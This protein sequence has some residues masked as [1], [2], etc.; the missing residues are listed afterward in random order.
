M[1][2]LGLCALAATLLPLPGGAVEVRPISVEGGTGVPVSAAAAGAGASLSLVPR[3]TA[4]A[5]TAPSLAA[6]FL[7]ASGQGPRSAPARANAGA[8]AAAPAAAAA[9]ADSGYA[10]PEDELPG[11]ASHRRELLSDV[12]TLTALAD[13]LQARV[14]IS[15]ESAGVASDY[16]AAVE[17]L[18]GAVAGRL[19]DLAAEVA[20]GKATAADVDAAARELEPLAAHGKKIADLVMM[21]QDLQQAAHRDQSMTK[22]RQIADWLLSPLRPSEQISGDSPIRFDAD[23][24]KTLAHRAAALAP[25]SPAAAPH[26]RFAQVPDPAA[27][28]ERPLARP[29]E[30]RESSLEEAIRS[31]LKGANNRAKNA[32][33]AALT[34]AFAIPLAAINPT[35]EGIAIHLG[36]LAAAFG[37]GRLNLR[38]YKKRR[39]AGL[40]PEALA[41]ERKTLAFLKRLFWLAGIGFFLSSMKS[42]ALSATILET[43]AAYAFITM[44]ELSSLKTRWLLKA[45]APQALNSPVSERLPAPSIAEV[46]A[47][48]GGGQPET[49]FKSQ[50]A[51]WLAANGYVSEPDA[52]ISRGHWGH[53]PND[54]TLNDGR[55]RGLLRFEGKEI[56]L[57]HSLFAEQRPFPLSWF[58]DPKPTSSDW[59]QAPKR[60]LAR[61]RAGDNILILDYWTTAT[62][63][64]PYRGTPE[65]AIAA[66]VF[67]LRREGDDYQ[68]YET[69]RLAI[70]PA[71]LTPHLQDPAVLWRHSD[72]VSP[73]KTKRLAERL[74]LR[75]TAE[76][77]AETADGN[78]E[79]R[80]WDE[81]EFSAL[82]ETRLRLTDEV[83]RLA[84]LYEEAENIF[85]R[86]SALNMNPAEVEMLAQERNRI[87]LALAEKRAQLRDAER[88]QQEKALDLYG[89]V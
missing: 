64:D 62:N 38:A 74:G 24:L 25:A 14:K 68:V 36:A 19:Q 35:F 63:D 21:L 83:G 41:R 17:L 60:I 15:P 77:A 54:H 71:G 43:L 86:E 42:A 6:P 22:A 81:K 47:P 50:W 11:A 4:T 18:R 59:E 5:L 32:L 40:R 72:R 75:I 1:S 10:E 87:E 76:A 57:P 85:A 12:P 56:E 13:D 28:P 82:S 67:A 45:P 55:E 66:T 26:G 20:A 33:L 31:A 53:Q 16:D 48:V 3:L 27:A 79:E 2:R 30:T 84:A 9:L 69:E 89:G 58:M 37:L 29:G 49:L 46:P 51:D 80:Q 70:G 73:V 44:G 52:T 23:K 88:A 65:A 8:S 39:A 34:L 7:S 78:R 61:D